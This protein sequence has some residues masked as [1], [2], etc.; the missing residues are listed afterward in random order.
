M[1]PRYDRF[2]WRVLRAPG[3]SPVYG[4]RLVVFREAFQ[5]H[6]A[7]QIFMATPRFFEAP[8]GRS[9]R[10]KTPHSYR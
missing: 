10:L 3:V 1:P 4:E 5:R 2:Y 6:A 8:L 7:V 9:C